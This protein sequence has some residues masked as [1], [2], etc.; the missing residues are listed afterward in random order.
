MAEEK[1]INAAAPAEEEQVQD[2]NE[3]KQ[4]RVEKLEALQA[5]GKDPFEITLADQSI[6]CSEIV[7]RFEELENSDVSICGRMM[8]RRDMGKANFIDIRDLTGRMQIYVKIDEIGEESFAEFKKW[9]IGDII[10]VKGFVFRTRRGEISVHAKALRLL[11]KSLLTL[12][13]KFHC[14]TNTETRYRKRY[15]DLIMNPEVKDTFVK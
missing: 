10:E 8:S 4:I 2:V 12:P 7:E 1:N 15:L 13:E 5:A 6:H 9:D 11:S 14:L 3:L